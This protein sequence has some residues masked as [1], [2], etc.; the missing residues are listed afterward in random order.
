MNTIVV[1]LLVITQNVHSGSYTAIQPYTFP[2]VKDCEHVINGL[3]NART[4][5]ARCVQTTIIKG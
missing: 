5:I 4:R 1:W 3:P 2:T